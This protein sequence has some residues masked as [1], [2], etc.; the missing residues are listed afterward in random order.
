MFTC[1]HTLHPNPTHTRTPTRTHTPPLGVSIC[2]PNLKSTNVLKYTHNGKKKW[3]MFNNVDT[4]PFLLSHNHLPAENTTGTPAMQHAVAARHTAA[5]K[6]RTSAR[7]SR[8]SASRQASATAV[9]TYGL[10]MHSCSRQHAHSSAVQ[11]P[12]PTNLSREPTAD[13]RGKYR[14]AHC[15]ESVPAVHSFL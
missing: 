6:C 11:H 10:P 5:A 12:H 14:A 8:I 1:T 4:H 13:G 3:Q 15:V 9:K 7:M 2:C